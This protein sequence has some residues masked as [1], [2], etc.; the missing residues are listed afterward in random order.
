MTK[1]N[2]IRGTSQKMN[3]AYV[4][5]KGKDFENPEFLKIVLTRN[6]KKGEEF[7]TVYGD[8]YWGFIYFNIQILKQSN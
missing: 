2:D 8:D 3:C 7:L 6:V 4:Q 5:T 1:I